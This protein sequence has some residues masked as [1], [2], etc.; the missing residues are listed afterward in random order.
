MMLDLI[1]GGMIAVVSI[2]AL[3]PSPRILYLHSAL[4]E[5]KGSANTTGE[6]NHDTRSVL[7]IH[8]LCIFC[9]IDTLSSGL[10]YYP[11]ILLFNAIGAIG[12]SI[13]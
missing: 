1:I 4:Q 13:G 8:F 11:T 2:L 10:L 9:L 6:G 3:Y 5:I 7:N 12:S